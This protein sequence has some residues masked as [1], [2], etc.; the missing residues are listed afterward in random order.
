PGASAASAATWDAGSYSRCG[1]IGFA[2]P[3]RPT[4]SDGGES[5][6]LLNGRP[7]TQ[8]PPLNIGSC[9]MT[10]ARLN[11]ASKTEGHTRSQVSPFPAETSG[12]QREWDTTRRP[13]VHQ[14]AATDKPRPTESPG[15]AR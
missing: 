13:G 10:V 15:A 6:A 1:G 3:T 4:G 5:Q 9:P 12:A 7:P 2:K 8:S 14:S 11:S